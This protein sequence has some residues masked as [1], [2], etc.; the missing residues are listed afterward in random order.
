MKLEINNGKIRF[1][2]SLPI[3]PRR[4]SVALFRLATGYD[5]LPNYLF[6]LG[7]RKSK[8]LYLWRGCNLECTT[9]ALLCLALSS[10]CISGMYWE[11]ME[12]EYRRA[13]A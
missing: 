2:I 1:L 5:C 6:R 10:N 11:A 7:A 3:R 12:L 13:S 8:L 9:L 4:T